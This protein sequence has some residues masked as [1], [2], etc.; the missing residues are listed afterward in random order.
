MMNFHYT[1][2]FGKTAVLAMVVMVSCL[3]HIATGEEPFDIAEWV[4][5]KQAV[6]VQVENL[7]EL[8]ETLRGLSV[9]E[10]KDVKALDAYFR[11]ES[12]QKLLSRNGFQA[13]GNP[14][15]AL[16]GLLSIPV[17][18]F[19]GELTLLIDSK[20]DEDGHLIWKLSG[21]CPLKSAEHVAEVVHDLM[22]A[23]MKDFSVESLLKEVG[24]VENIAI[25]R[26]PED[27]GVWCLYENA[28]LLF[29][30]QPA[31][32][33][34]LKQVSRKIR[35]KNSFA[36]SR[37][38][39]S[40]LQRADR[41]ES[42][43]AGIKIYFDPS[44]AA[45]LFPGMLPQAWRSLGLNEIVGSMIQ[46]SL[47]PQPANGQSLR[48]QVV[49]DAWIAV[50]RP[51]TAIVESILSAPPIEKIPHLPNDDDRVD[52]FQAFSFNAKKLFEAMRVS[53][54]E[55]YG[56]GL[57]AKT[58][59][60][61]N[62]R[63]RISFDIEHVLIPALG[64]TF[65]KMRMHHSEANPELDNGTVMVAASVGDKASAKQVIK[66]LVKM[67][68][69]AAHGVKL[70]ETDIDGTIAWVYSPEAIEQ[71][72][73]WIDKMNQ[74]Q[75]GD[76][77]KPNVFLDGIAA[78]TA[79]MRK[80]K[81]YSSN[82]DLGYLL[83]E[84]WGFNGTRR[85]LFT[86]P[87]EPEE[88]LN[89]TVHEIGKMYRYVRQRDADVAQ[90]FFVWAKWPETFHSIVSGWYLTT[91]REKVATGNAD[92]QQLL[93]FFINGE[94]PSLESVDNIHDLRVQVMMRGSRAIIDSFGKMIITVSGESYGLRVSGAFFSN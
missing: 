38:L 69:T 17:D 8:D 15:Y 68:D 59:D 47:V 74:S 82:F 76:P 30:S 3:L 88:T 36:Q 49:V 11:S 79:K 44:I 80:S 67:N 77:D 65:V 39:V 4:D 83:T 24:T 19:D 63:E 9:W 33:G 13:S 7:E 81:I 71:I 51:H 5:A 48:P 72:E 6:M 62:A 86:L 42:K 14:A 90:P 60:E 61:I 21:R 18:L 1:S 10:H 75:R 40:A 84:S 91:N 89:D 22:P 93:K 27:L 34:F 85:H 52:E 55:I 23:E 32:V 66:G 16:R 70:E 46:I 57:F 78:E 64:G 94:L 58:L 28:L 43:A 92:A 31:A 87:S 26:I 37:K 29:G 54:D 45:E 50:T 25:Y 20:L 2:V 12:C 56:E 35:P 53:Y 73:R 41:R